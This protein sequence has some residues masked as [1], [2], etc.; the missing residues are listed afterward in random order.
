MKFECHRC[1]VPIDHYGL[2]KECDEYMDKW[3]EKNKYLYII[4]CGGQ[5]KK[6]KTP[7]QLT[8]IGGEPIIARTIRLLKEN[9][10]ETKNIAISSNLEGFENFGVKVL[11]HNN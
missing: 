5:Y 4:M 11:K 6:W 3:A 2:C 7:R 10:I 9:E 1:G 8:K